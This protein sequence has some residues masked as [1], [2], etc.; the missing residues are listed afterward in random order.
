MI[1]LDF[2]SRSRTL[3]GRRGVRGLY[4]YMDDPTTLPLMA[5]YRINAG[6]MRRWRYTSPD[7]PDDLREAVESGMMITAHNA[8]FERL[9]MQKI[10]AP[11]YGWPFPPTEQFRCTAATAAAMALPR[12][13]EH[14]GVALGLAQ[15][16]DKAGK[17]LIDLFSVPRKPRKDEDPNGLYFNEPDDFPVEFEQFHD[18]CDD[19]VL[20]EA[21]ADARMVPLSDD[22][23]AVYVLSE[24]INDRGLRIDRTSA[25]AALRLAEKAKRQLDAELC[26]VTGGYV[27]STTTPAKLVEW[28]A[29]QGVVMNSAKKAEIEALLE[30]DDLPENVRRAIEIRQEGGKTSV[31]KLKKMLSYGNDDDGR[32]RGSFIYHGASPGR[33]QSVGVNFYNMPRPRREFDDAHLNPAELFE[34]IRTEEPDY[35]RALYGDVLGR[36]LH[37]LSDAVRGFV[38]SAPGCEFMQADYSGIE[39]A[40]IAWTSGEHWKVEALHAILADPSIPDMY[41]QTAAGILDVPVESSAKGGENYWSRQAVGKISELALGFGGGVAA[42]HSMSLN[43]SVKLSPLFGPVW[44]KADEERR[45]KAVK[46]YERCLKLGKEK[47]D[48]LPREAWLASELIKVGWRAT[49][50]AITKGWSLREDAIREAIR[51]PGQTTRALM[52]SYVVKLGYLWCMLPS[53]RCL[54]YA[55]PKLRDQVW[56]KTK[57]DDGSWSESEVMGRFEAEQL[58]KDGLVKIE[59]SSSPSITA[60]GVSKS[61]AMQRE[62][63]YGGLFAENDT[64]AVARDLLVNGMRKAEGAGYPIKLVIYDEILAEIPRGAGDLAAFE[65]LICELPDWAAGLPLT[66]GG[67]RSKRYK[68]G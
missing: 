13:L 10:M 66:A 48:L 44:A 3:L 20:T 67:F 57:L 6:P 1:E 56:A 18:Y 19:D 26:Q 47:T 64:Q 53:G 17:K 23:Q 36:P 45:A 35:L 60:L 49:N 55:S 51:N 2:E 21:A 16:K 9:M 54:A 7:C 22:E 8:A 32:V 43:Y 39:G 52:F 62:H 5:S 33:W 63:F 11:R 15:Q 24:K 29:Q 58:V 50:P 31:S 68:K 40:V 4:N 14:L 65:K 30:F 61:G 28:V 12:S 27:R 38:W 34:A 41:R 25:R 42:F 37:L 46:R 59:G